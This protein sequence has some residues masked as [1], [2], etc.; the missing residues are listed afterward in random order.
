M[1]KEALL[2]CNLFL[3]IFTHET[4][5]TVKPAEL[6]MGSGGYPCHPS[7]QTQISR[8]LK[9][10]RGMKVNE[11]HTWRKFHH[12]RVK[13]ILRGTRE[14]TAPRAGEWDLRRTESLGKATNMAIKLDHLQK[15]LE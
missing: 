11:T 2:H 5:E 13:T 10:F 8:F 4:S 1:N 15:N 12:A 3:W 14:D 9:R 7:T 6:Q